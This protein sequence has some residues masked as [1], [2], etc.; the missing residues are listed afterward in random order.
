MQ[1]P[2]R[3]TSACIASISRPRRSVSNV[4]YFHI[5]SSEIDINFPYIS[6]AGS[7][8]PIAFPSDFDIFC[9]PSS[10]S[11]IGVISTICCGCPQCSLQI[12]PTHQVE[13]LVRPAQLHIA[14]QRHRVIPLRQRIQ[15]L[16]HA[17]RLLFL[18]PLM[19]VLALQH[20]A[21]A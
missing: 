3:D 6:P 2:A 17:N 14:L 19:K 9:T 5:S 7:C 10:P 18:E 21:T 11:R 15:Q 13:L 12:A 8:I 16:M 20:L 4:Q 1:L